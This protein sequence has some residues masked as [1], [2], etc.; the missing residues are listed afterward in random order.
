MSLLW[1]RNGPERGEREKVHPPRWR[2]NGEGR[3]WHRNGGVHPACWCRNGDERGEGGPLPAGAE[4]G[5]N[6]GLTFNPRPGAKT[7]TDQGTL[8]PGVETEVNEKGGGFAPSRRRNGGERGSWGRDGG[9][10]PQCSRRKKQGRVKPSLFAPMAEGLGPLS[11]GQ[12]CSSRRKGW[13]GI[14]PSLLAATLR[15]QKEKKKLRG[16]LLRP[17]SSSCSTPGYLSPRRRLWT[18]A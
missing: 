8:L 7:E 15:Q 2:Q 12:N 4:I 16:N 6:E 18:E 17:F 10:F 3:P 11:R 14:V 1:R 13:G 5:V 9:R